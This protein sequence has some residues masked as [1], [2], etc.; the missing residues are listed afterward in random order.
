MYRVEFQVSGSPHI[1]SFFWVNDA[2]KL[3]ADAEDKCLNFIENIISAKFPDSEEKPELYSFIKTFLIYTH[4]NTWRKCNDDECS[5]HYVRF[6]LKK[7]NT[8]K[9]ITN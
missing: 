6:F 1:L 9:T 7:N 4:S 2:P 8:G 5:F 3:D